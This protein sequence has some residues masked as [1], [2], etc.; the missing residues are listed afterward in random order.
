MLMLKAQIRQQCIQE[1][2]GNLNQRCYN[3]EQDRTVL[4]VNDEGCFGNN[5][6][7]DSEACQESAILNVY[8]SHYMH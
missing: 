7:N 8:K 2:Y 5:S 6:G 4:K 3:S 1:N